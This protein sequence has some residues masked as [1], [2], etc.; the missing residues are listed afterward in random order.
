MEHI[1]VMV[2]DDHRVVRRA[3]S[4]AFRTFDKLVL[5]GEAGNGEEAIRLCDELRPDVVLMDLVM[6][7]MNGIEATKRIREHY[8]DTKIIIMTAAEED[9]MVE[10]VLQA[11]ATAVLLKNASIDEFVNLIFGSVGT[12][13]S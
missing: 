3:L 4:L 1:R 7:E 10:D 6:P 13:P 8:P 12:L 9:N 11:G 5:V 2:V